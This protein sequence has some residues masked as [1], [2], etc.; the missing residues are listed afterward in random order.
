MKTFRFRIQTANGG[1]VS[2]SARGDS[3]DNAK[4]RLYKQYP[5]CTVID[6]RE[7]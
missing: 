6:A 2:T 4:W 5:G 3:L 7:G 1:I